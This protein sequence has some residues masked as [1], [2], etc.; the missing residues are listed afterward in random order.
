M[1]AGIGLEPGQQCP[2]CTAT[3]ERNRMVRYAAVLEHGTRIRCKPVGSFFT[4]DVELREHV[5][6]PEPIP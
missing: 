1:I 4:K 5:V 3:G 6:P 2:V